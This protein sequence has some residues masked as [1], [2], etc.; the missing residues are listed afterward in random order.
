LFHTKKDR[1]K[2]T[3]CLEY[4]DTVLNLKTSQQ[5]SLSTLSYHG[6]CH[7]STPYRIIFSCNRQ[8]GL[9][10]CSQRYYLL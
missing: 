2:N 9:A 6:T 10:C 1:T 3:P 8:S 7:S 4:F 5:I